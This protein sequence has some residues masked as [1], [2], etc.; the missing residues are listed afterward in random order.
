MN[1]GTN[2]PVQTY[3]RYIVSIL[4]TLS[5]IPCFLTIVNIREFSFSIFDFLGVTS[6]IDDMAAEYIEITDFIYGQKIIFMLTAMAVMI[7]PM[8][9]SI[10]VCLADDLTSRVAA[11]LG[12][13]VSNVALIIFYT[14]MKDM[15]DYVKSTVVGH[16]SSDSIITYNLSIVLWVMIY[17]VIA[18]AIVPSLADLRKKR[19]MRHSITRSG[20]VIMKKK[21]ASGE[22]GE[23]QE[24]VLIKP[25][26]AYDEA[27]DMIVNSSRRCPSCGAKVGDSDIFCDICGMK[28]E[29]DDADEQEAIAEPEVKAPAGAA[30]CSRCGS[31]LRAGASFCGKCGERIK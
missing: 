17:I 1:K 13:I 6:G 11:A 19:S 8:A 4:M 25:R 28:I 15:L 5:V 10:V 20:G 9:A 21:R 31:P 29:P 26:T 27:R 7:L 30:V 24:V 14:R 3:F 16:L 2:K 12:V 22:N 23:Q 18:L